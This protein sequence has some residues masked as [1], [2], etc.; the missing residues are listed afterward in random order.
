MN[1]LTKITKRQDMAVVSSRVLVEQLGKRHDNVIRDIEEIIKNSTTKI[2]IL[3]NEYSSNLRATQDLT[4]SDL[5][6]L[7]KWKYMFY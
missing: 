3:L 6:T 5:R 1:K 2:S 4:N 7:K